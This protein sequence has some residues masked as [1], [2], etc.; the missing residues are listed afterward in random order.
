[1][2][3]TC[4]CG[5]SMSV[6][7]RDQQ[8]FHFCVDCNVAIP[9]GMVTVPPIRVSRTPS[10]ALK[11]LE[12]GFGGDRHDYQVMQEQQ[13]EDLRRRARGDD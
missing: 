9:A 8:S 11:A 6:I 4:E 3:Q 1:M 7:Y 2:N 13:R 10:T 5:E 12:R